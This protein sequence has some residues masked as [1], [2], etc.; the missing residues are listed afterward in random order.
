MSTN[1]QIA[2]NRQNSQASAGPVTPEGKKKSALNATRHGFTGQSLVITDE[3]KGFYETH[4]ISYMEQFQPA[5]HEETDLI[6][7]Y[8]DLRWSL[9]Q[10]SVQQSNVMS[11]INALTAQ[12][13]AAGDLSRPTTKLS[14]RSPPTNSAA[15]EPPKL[16]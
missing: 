13:I 16:R 9:H 12:L 1:A 7:Q 2:A 11:L 3:E 8:A 15:A 14:T 4:S 10:I 6:Q 5:T